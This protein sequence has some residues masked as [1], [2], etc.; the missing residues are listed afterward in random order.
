M[1]KKY[2]DFTDEQR[3]R[4]AERKKRWRKA[5]HKKVLAKDRAY[6]AANRETI[7][8]K[9]GIRQKLGAEKRRERLRKWWAANRER[10]RAQRKAWR[11]A[12]PEKNALWRKRWQQANREKARSYTRKYEA[13]KIAE[14]RQYQDAVNFVAMIQVSNAIEKINQKSA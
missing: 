7:I 1:S 11:L 10:L 8:A 13:A 9:Q 6:Y 2:S 12:N 4:E 14:R 5:N 3:A